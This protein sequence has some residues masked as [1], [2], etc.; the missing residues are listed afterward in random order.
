MP[1]RILSR[2]GSQIFL[3]PEGARVASGTNVIVPPL[4]DVESVGPD[5]S[6]SLEVLSQDSLAFEGLIK[7]N[8][9]R[10]IAGGEVNGQPLGVGEQIEL[11]DLLF[12]GLPALKPFE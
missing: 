5:V 3:G 7:V 8:A 9:A 11:A 4:I 1:I 10:V 12:F 6:V 2:G